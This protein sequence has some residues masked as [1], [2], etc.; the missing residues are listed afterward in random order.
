MKNILSAG[1]Q[2]KISSIDNKP[3]TISEKNLYHEPCWFINKTDR[4]IMLGLDSMFVDLLPEIK[5]VVFPPAGSVIR[6]NQ[7]LSWLLTKHGAIIL[8]SPVQGR[9]ISLNNKIVESFKNKKQ[10]PEKDFSLMSL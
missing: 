7:V 6:K 1:F 8:K 4:F 10:G 9:I 5:D 3:I 2:K